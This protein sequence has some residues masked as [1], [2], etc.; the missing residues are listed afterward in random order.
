MNR[1]M[2]ATQV[3]RKTL[4]PLET[5]DK[6]DVSGTFAYLIPGSPLSRTSGMSTTRLTMIWSVSM[7]EGRASLIRYLGPA[8]NTHD[9]IAESSMSNPSTTDW[10]AP[11]RSHTNSS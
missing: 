11:N 2:L 6:R 7:G 8:S 4:L 3:R 5:K 9:L 10:T 1:S